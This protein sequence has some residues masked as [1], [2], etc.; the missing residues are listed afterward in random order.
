MNRRLA[1][2]TKVEF[3][4][5]VLPIIPKNKRGFSSSV[6]SFEIFTCIVHKLKTGSQWSNLFID[7]ESVKPN[8]S[9]QLVYYFYRKWTQAGVFEKLF[10][11]SLRKKA[12]LLDTGKL[13]LDGTQ[14]LAK[15]AGQAIGYQLRKRGKTSN[16]LIMTDGKG[17]PIAIGDILCGNHNDLYEVVPQFSSM[18]KTL[19]QCGV[20][21]GG[22]ILTAD[23]GFDSQSLRRACYRKKIF[24]NVKENKRNRKKTNGVKSAFS[25]Q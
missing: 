18:I 19:N 5:E 8:F 24:P 23:K 14:S 20:K 21:T 7:L 17:I 13:N 6:D 12:G 11:Y 9:W 2:I 25:I 3:E 15:K 22:S 10:R 1:K 4:T 16:V